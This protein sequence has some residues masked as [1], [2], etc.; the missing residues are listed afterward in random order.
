M[1]AAGPLAV[2]LLERVVGVVV[3]SGLRHDAQQRGDHAA[4]QRGETALAE[5]HLLERVAETLVLLG[6]QRQKREGQPGQSNGGKRVCRAALAE[7]LLC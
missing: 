6:L 4:V 1:F 5:H 2:A 3:D 7:V